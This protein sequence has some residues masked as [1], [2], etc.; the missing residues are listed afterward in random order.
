MGGVLALLE[1]P[2]PAAVAKGLVALALL[3]RACPR[4]LAQALRARLLPQVLQAPQMGLAG[5]GLCSSSMHWL[6]WLRVCFGSPFGSAGMRASCACAS[7]PA[8]QEAGGMR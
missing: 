5:S 7:I 1:A 4:F 8:H 3:T 2:Q 6:S